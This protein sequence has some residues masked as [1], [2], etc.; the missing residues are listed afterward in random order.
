M[1]FDAFLN[2]I[3][4]GRLPGLTVVLGGP[5]Y[6]FNRMK[7]VLSGY[8]GDESVNVMDPDAC[9]G[10][11]V[12]EAAE[13]LDMFGGNNVYVVREFT[14]LREQGALAEVVANAHRFK[15]SIILF[16]SSSAAEKAVKKKPFSAIPPS[17]VVQCKRLYEKDTLRLVRERFSLQG[18]EISSEAL[19]MLIAMNEDNTDIL[20]RAVETLSTYAGENTEI[21]L[22]AVMEFT[23]NFSSGT[24]FD[25]LDHVREREKGAF[26][27]KMGHLLKTGDPGQPLMAISMI[28]NE[29]KKLLVVKDNISSSPEELSKLTGLHPYVIKIKNYVRGAAAIDRNVMVESL[30]RICV[31]DR[32]IKTGQDP[33]MT[34]MYALNPI[35]DGVSA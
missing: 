14:A 35:F 25:C 7:E 3:E 26:A 8:Y 6:Y 24:I 22:F 19:E 13:N 32:E 21:D 15:N 9:D 27:E 2:V 17:S 33:M 4:K 30:R 20:F 28:Y 18:K 11:S 34:I 31:A 29:L 16:S 23:G 12:L 5:G 10:F 1:E